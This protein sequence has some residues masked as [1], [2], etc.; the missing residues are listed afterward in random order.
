LKLPVL[1]L[2]IRGAGETQPLDP[3][4]MRDAPDQLRALEIG[5]IEE[6]LALL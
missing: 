2:V 6:Q 1:V 4:P 5:K 3:G